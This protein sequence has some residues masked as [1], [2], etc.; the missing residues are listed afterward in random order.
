MRDREDENAVRFYM[1][2]LMT[3]WNK[4]FTLVCCKSRWKE[5]SK[6]GNEVEKA[7]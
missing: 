7:F 4:G 2:V 6:G 5:R 3:A 1:K